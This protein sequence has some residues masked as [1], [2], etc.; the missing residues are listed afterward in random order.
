MADGSF[1]SRQQ[2]TWWLLDVHA[3][4]LLLITVESHLN[5]LAGSK[6]PQSSR[7]CL[8]IPPLSVHSFVIL[9][10]LMLFPRHNPGSKHCHLRVTPAY[11]TTCPPMALYW[12]SLPATGTPCTCLYLPVPHFFLSK[13]CTWCPPSHLIFVHPETLY[14]GLIGLL[15]ISL[16]DKIYGGTEF[17]G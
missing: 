14:P 4:W 8:H 10:L 11:F 17:Q 3:P 9:A 16:E 15:N 6:I 7:E 5:P 13:I 12:S 1:I 2:A